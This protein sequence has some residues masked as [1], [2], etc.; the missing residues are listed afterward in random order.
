MSKMTH[1]KMIPRTRY[2]RMELWRRTEDSWPT[3]NH[4]SK[5]MILI[6][7]SQNRHEARERHFFRPVKRQQ[8]SNSPNVTHSVSKI[9]EKLAEEIVRWLTPEATWPKGW[10]QILEYRNRVF[11]LCSIASDSG[12]HQPRKKFGGDLHPSVSGFTGGPQ[13]QQSRGLILKESLFARPGVSERQPST[14]DIS[15]HSAKNLAQVTVYRE[16]LLIV[17]RG[18]QKHSLSGAAGSNKQSASRRRKYS[19]PGWPTE[20]VLEPLSIRL[21]R[22]E[23]RLVIFHRRYPLDSAMLSLSDLA[24]LQP[25][26]SNTRDSAT[27]RSQRTGSGDG[28]MILYLFPAALYSLR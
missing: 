7:K 23:R 16:V 27:S 15:R 20:H 9:I 21:F 17:S 12:W 25:I 10:E 14:A 1:V 11:L 4:G 6:Q 3:R 8:Q 28:L 24:T 26:V 2:G 19:D 18:P 13:G 22:I 5:G